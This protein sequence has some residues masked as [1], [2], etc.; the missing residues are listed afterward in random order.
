MDG[1]ELRSLR[2]RFGLTQAEVARI[3]GLQQPALSAM[4]NGR[5]GSDAA[6]ER[7]RMAIVA[8]TRPSTVLDDLT[9][10]A[11]KVT[12]GTYG[13]TNIRIFGSVARGQDDPGSDL[14]LI[15]EFPSGFDLFDLMEAETAVEAIV[16]IPVDIVSESP[17]TAYALKRA[18]AEAV[19]L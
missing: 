4:E 12:L 19:P 15:A 5:R 1:H 18:K 16:G 17:R 9:K 13:A 2:K 10:D 3:S 11:I 14:D 6:F 8:A 7:V